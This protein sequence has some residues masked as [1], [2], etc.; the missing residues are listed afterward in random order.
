LLP[1]VR[2][3]TSTSYSHPSSIEGYLYGDARDA[4]IF[5]GVQLRV[6]RAPHYPSLIRL[7]RHRCFIYDMYYM[8]TLLCSYRSCALCHAPSL[9]PF[10]AHRSLL[11]R[12]SMVF[13]CFCHQPSAPVLIK[14]VFSFP[15]CVLFAKTF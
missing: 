1:G 12:V 8:C 2:T 11:S 13:V 3:S 15:V 4:F 5:H 6:F 9:S 14:L 10:Y 7:C